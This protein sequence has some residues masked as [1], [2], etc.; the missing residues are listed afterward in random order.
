MKFEKV[1]M[2]STPRRVLYDLT[3]ADKNDKLH[4]ADNDEIWKNDE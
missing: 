4:E 1:L 2:P 3:V